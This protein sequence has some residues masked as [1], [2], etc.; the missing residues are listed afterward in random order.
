VRLLEE[1]LRL[2]DPRTEQSPVDARR[3]PG[4]TNDMIHPY[5]NEVQSRWDR[6]EFKVQLNVANNTRPMGFCDGTDED[7][8]E[9][10][11]I[12]EEEGADEYRI[13]RKVLKSGREIW[14]LHGG[15]PAEDDGV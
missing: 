9:L 5:G 4:Y 14:T 3:A 2:R 10:E 6:G 12:A 7:L 13:E 8:A 11:A 15:G 1:L